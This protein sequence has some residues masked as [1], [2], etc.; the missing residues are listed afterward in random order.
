MLVHEHDLRRA[1]QS[2]PSPFEVNQELSSEVAENC[3]R[4]GASSEKLLPLE[5]ENKILNNRIQALEN[6][7][8]QLLGEMEG[9][10]LEGQLDGRSRQEDMEALQES[11][12]SL[13]YLAV[14]MWR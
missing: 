14:N 5:A 9:R 10:P 13:R 7:C 3:P 1:D 11:C 4:L 6:E 12:D 2:L 8:T